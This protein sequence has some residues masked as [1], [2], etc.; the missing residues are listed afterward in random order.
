MFKIY[1]IRIRKKN[2]KK[3]R[4]INSKM[5]ENCRKFK[6]TSKQKKEK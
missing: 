4:K 3:K 2:N 5:N 6:K 1:K